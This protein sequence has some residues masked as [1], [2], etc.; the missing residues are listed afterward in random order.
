MAYQRPAQQTQGQQ[1]QGQSNNN[2]GGQ[3]KPA[4][5]AS[6]KGGGPKKAGADGP[7]RPTFDLVLCDEEGELLTWE[8]VGSDSVELAATAKKFGDQKTA[9]VGA[10]WMAESGGSGVLRIGDLVLKVFPVSDKTEK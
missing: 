5:A 6:N 4:G 9:K 7:K 10:I 3:T 8:G 2:R 1:G